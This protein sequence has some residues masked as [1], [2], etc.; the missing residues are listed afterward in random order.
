MADENSKRIRK[1]LLM[2]TDFVTKQ[3]KETAKSSAELKAELFAVIDL[4]K[5]CGKKRQD[6]DQSKVYC[7]KLCEK[8]RGTGMLRMRIEF[9]ADQTR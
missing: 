8:T 3:Q 4:Q 1:T 5:L 2:T 6:Q 7:K 9:Q